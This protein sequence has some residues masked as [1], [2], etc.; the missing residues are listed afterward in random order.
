[1]AIAIAFQPN[2]TFR[3]TQY[4]FLDFPIALPMERMPHKPSILLGA[5]LYCG[6]LSGDIIKCWNF[7]RGMKYTITFQVGL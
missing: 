5:V 3:P 1:M 7:Q 4:D 2:T 6:P